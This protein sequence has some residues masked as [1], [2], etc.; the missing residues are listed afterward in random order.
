VVRNRDRLKYLAGTEL[1]AG[2]FAMD[3]LPENTAAELQKVI[4][5]LE[6][7]A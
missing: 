7:D 4:V 1:G 3:T 2:M 6:E 5:N